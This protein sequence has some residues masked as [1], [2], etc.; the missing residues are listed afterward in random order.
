[1]KGKVIF[2]GAIIALLFGL[3][4][5]RQVFSASYSQSWVYQ[6]DDQA[7]CV[8]I[9]G[10]G[11][12][13]VVGTDDAAHLI[14]SSSGAR[15]W[16]Y[17]TAYSVV[18]VTMTSEAEVIA[19]AASGGYFFGGKTYFFVDRAATPDSTLDSD[20]GFSSIAFSPEGNYFVATYPNGLG[21]NDDVNLWGGNEGKWLWNHGVGREDSSA[22]ALPANGAYTAV[23]ASG[24]VFSI[25]GV[26]LYDKSGNLVWKYDI[27]DVFSGGKYSV[28]ISPDGNRIVAGNDWKNDI[29]LL[30]RVQKLIWSRDMGGGIKGVSMPGDG[31]CFLVATANVVSLLDNNQNVLWSVAISQ[32]TDAKISSDA[33]LIVIATASG[34]VYGFKKTGVTPVSWTIWNTCPRF[35]SVQKVNVVCADG[36][37]SALIR[38]SV[39][40][41]YNPQTLSA[42]VVS[43]GATGEDGFIVSASAVAGELNLRYMS[44]ESFCRAGNATDPNSQS[45]QIKI[46]IL[47]GSTVLGVVNFNL[48]RPPLVMLHGLWGSASGWD[49]FVNFFEN[50]CKLYPAGLLYA[51]DYTPTNAASF[52]ENKDIC[53]KA[54]GAGLLQAR[55]NGYSAGKVDVVGHS[56]GGILARWYLRNLGSRRYQG[57][58]HKFISIGAPHS[59]S[60]LADLAMTPGYYQVFSWLL[61]RTRWPIDKGAVENLRVD[62]VAIDVTL[63]MLSARENKVPSHTVATT[64][65]K[66]PEWGEDW[67]EIIYDTATFLL[68]FKTPDLVPLALFRESNDY[69]VALSSQRGG[70]LATTNIADVFHLD[71]VKDVDV[72]Q[73]ARDL[74]NADSQGPSF[75]QAGFNPQDLHYAIPLPSLQ[76]QLEKQ[77][78][79]L[80]ASGTVKITSPVPDTRVSAGN[81]IS[82]VVSASATIKKMIVAGRDQCLTKTAPPFSF[83]FQV[84]LD[85]LGPYDIAA[86]GFGDNG[87]V[88]M[89]SIQ[90][91]VS[92]SARLIAIRVFPKTMLVAAKGD[93]ANVSALGDYSD[94]V[95]RDITSGLCGTKYAIADSAVAAVAGDGV[96]LG[97][98]SGRTTL[99]ISN[100]AVS[101]PLQ[102]AVEDMAEKTDVIRWMWYK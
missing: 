17:G 26:W 93:K 25:G 52:A 81:N 66:L 53:D 79:R 21:W 63:N 85:A 67:P 88:A 58:I 99:T 28:D 65:Q 77:P 27:G 74:L 40:K 48:F 82:V 15:M 91:Q 75:S 90:I 80:A 4:A 18:S 35:S 12:Y 72:Q 14:N 83:V 13:T 98:S 32:V 24:C 101:V 29:Y 89:D 76:S 42:Q 2:F 36:S 43:S 39:D 51:Y 47:S 86:L 54:V 37:D 10:N 50:S 9:S 94:G 87:L 31:S 102:V 23:G 11:G 73:K 45:R 22:V 96:I 49:K 16:R 78:L 8:A 55:E 61:A 20:T 44:P 1:M 68:G 59:G 92:S 64:E 97:K 71:Q 19:A 57:D 38:V 46:N 30:G 33:S 5:S 60:H 56:M 6:A 41:S 7:N 69:V 62:S 70:C 95:S 84:P 3:A 100:G 34:K